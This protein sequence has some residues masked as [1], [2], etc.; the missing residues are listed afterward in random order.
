MHRITSQT[1]VKHFSDP[2]PHRN[3]SLFKAPTDEAFGDLLETALD[4]L[5]ITNQALKFN[6]SSLFDR[7]LMLKLA[8]RQASRQMS[9]FS[10]L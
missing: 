6:S 7:F 1:T 3:N 5:A 4:E 8:W 9:A 2:V 10:Q